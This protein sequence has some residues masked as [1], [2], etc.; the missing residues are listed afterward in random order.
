MDDY[1]LLVSSRCL[2]A[3]S[4]W[5]L[6]IRQSVVRLT[7]SSLARSFFRT[8]GGS[9]SVVP[10]GAERTVPAGA[11][12]SGNEDVGVIGLAELLG[13]L[14]P[15]AHTVADGN[16]VPEGVLGGQ[17]PAE[18]PRRTPKIGSSLMKTF[19]HHFPREQSS[20]CTSGMLFAQLCSK[21]HANNSSL[22]LVAKLKS[23][24]L[25]YFVNIF[26]R[27]LLLFL[28]LKRFISYFPQSRN[29]MFLVCFIFRLICAMGAVSP[30]LIRRRTPPDPLRFS[31]LARA[32]ILYTF[33]SL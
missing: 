33:I 27:S 4:S 2:R 14:H 6:V 3:A 12:R 32:G 1:E 25:E 18:L 9:T 19:L 21:F 7:P 29:E 16:D 24:F 28:F 11:G 23:S 13:D 5:R 8:V 26:V 17:A 31:P 30:M 10:P 22:S 20:S 15:A